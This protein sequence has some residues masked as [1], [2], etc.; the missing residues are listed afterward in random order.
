[1]AKPEI[2]EVVT[3]SNRRQFLRGQYL[4]FAALPQVQICATA[5]GLEY[6]NS[7]EIA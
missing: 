6:A 5:A 3:H 2:P 1:M 4:A 7:L